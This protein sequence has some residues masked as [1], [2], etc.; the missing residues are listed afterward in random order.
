MSAV[1]YGSSCKL[2]DGKEVKN[3]RQPVKHLK[4]KGIDRMGKRRAESERSE[5][6]RS[7]KTVRGRIFI[8]NAWM[9]ILPSL[10]I[11]QNW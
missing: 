8:S 11:R 9:I 5:K 1:F 2:R 7:E 4:E 6:E 10:L 3:A